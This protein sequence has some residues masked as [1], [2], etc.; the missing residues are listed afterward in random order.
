MDRDS[1]I[2]LWRQ[3][4]ADI[5]AA[6]RDGVYAPG[7]RLPVEAELARRYGVNRHTLRRAM[8]A[9]AENGLVRVE[10]GRGTFVQEHVVDYAV[11]PRMRMSEALIGQQRAP[12]GRL[13]HAEL[14]KADRTVAKNLGLRAGAGVVLLETLSEADGKPISVSQHYFPQSRCAGIAEAYRESGSITRALAACGVPDFIRR[15]TRIT[16]R[17]PGAIY[18][19]HLQQP[20]NR[21]ILMTESVNV[22]PDGRPIEYGIARFASDRVQLVHETMAR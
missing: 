22:D 7:S 5:A 20:A 2:A 11:G 16:A 17:L 15:T 12:G 13:L 6:I 19:R 4:E 8:A 14:R 21:P 10:Q 18:A 3:I 1:G 9:L